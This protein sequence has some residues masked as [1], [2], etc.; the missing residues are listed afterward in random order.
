M[1]I[2]CGSASWHQLGQLE[3]RRP[4]SSEGVLISMSDG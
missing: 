4:E 1:E 2:V 3:V